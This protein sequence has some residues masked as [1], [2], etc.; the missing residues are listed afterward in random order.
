MVVHWIPVM[1]YISFLFGIFLWGLCVM[2]CIIP[3]MFPLRLD[4]IGRL[5]FTVFLLGFYSGFNVLHLMS[6]CPEISSDA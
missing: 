3:L 2:S 1:T 6:F 4:T 5:S